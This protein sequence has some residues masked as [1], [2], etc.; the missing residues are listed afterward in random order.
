[1]KRNETELA[2][3]YGDTSGWLALDLLEKRSGP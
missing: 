3:A 1:M 2:F